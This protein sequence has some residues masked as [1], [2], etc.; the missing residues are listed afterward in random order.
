M[1]NRTEIRKATGLDAEAIAALLRSSFREFE[2]CYTPKAYDAT[3]LSPDRIRR[4][5]EEGP[6][7]VADAH[8]ELV[9]TISVVLGAQGIYIRSMAV[10]P[11]ARGRGV[12]RL[13]LDEI[14]RYASE[15]VCRRLYLSTTPFLEAAIALYE[16]VGFVRT[17]AEPHALYGT[18][19][20]TME[21][22]L[23]PVQYSILSDR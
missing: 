1:Y 15:N 5:I 23:D 7:W 19:L 16:R 9:G 3:V 18:P 12:A 14:E 17:D 13:L 10:H 20:F 21:K 2:P 22:H 6:V 8:N 4:R 11:D